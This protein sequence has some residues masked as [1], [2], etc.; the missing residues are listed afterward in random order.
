MPV[1][2]NICLGT[3]GWGV[4]HSPDSGKSWTRH[5]KPFPLNTRIQALVVHPT[6]AHTIVA[7]GDTGVFRSTDAGAHWERVGQQGDLPPS[8]LSRS[9]PSIRTCSSREPDR[10]ASI[11][12]RTAE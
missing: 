4:W 1:D 2:Y 9:I 7:A 8:G 10:R 5:R 11:A 6:D 12:R 3:A